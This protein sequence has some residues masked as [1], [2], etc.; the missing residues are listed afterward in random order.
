MSHRE[1]KQRPKVTEHVAPRSQHMTFKVSKCA[2]PA[3]STTYCFETRRTGRTTNDL[4]FNKDVAPQKQII[5]RITLQNLAP[6][7]VSITPP[8]RIA[9]YA[10][11]TRLSIMGAPSTP[12][13]I[14]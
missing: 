3:Q 12:A 14:T 2:P 9:K 13:V 1:N 4:H 5:Y 8:I 11:P 7:R 10:A 6:V